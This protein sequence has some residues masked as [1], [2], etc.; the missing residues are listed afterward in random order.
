MNP[1]A[2]KGEE[3]SKRSNSANKQVSDRGIHTDTN[4]VL[5]SARES[6]RTKCE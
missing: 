6:R 4:D 1:A 5:E 3:K 2:Q